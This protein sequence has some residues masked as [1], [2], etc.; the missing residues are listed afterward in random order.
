MDTDRISTLDG[1]T[2][3]FPPYILEKF[4][5]AERNL[6]EIYGKSPALSVLM[7]F[8]MACATP[9]SIC[10]EFEEAALD[11]TFQRISPIARGVVD[12]DCL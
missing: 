9:K 10:S 2:I 11:V 7:K 4:E 8:W 1:V 5:E 12:E 3:T 6:K